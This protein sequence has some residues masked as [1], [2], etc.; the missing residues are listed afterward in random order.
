M[1]REAAE[2]SVSDGSNTKRTAGTPTSRP[3]GESGGGTTPPVLEAVEVTKIYRMGP[4]EIRALDSL[5]LSIY[6]GEL[7]TVM[8]PSG[9]GKTTLLNVLGCLD[10]PDSGKVLLDGEDVTRLPEKART[11]IRLRKIGFIFQQF[12][13]IPTLTA[14]ENVMLPMLEAGLSRKRAAERGR[15]LLEEVGM[16][17]RADHRPSQMS[18]GEQQRTAIAR[19]L[20]N[21]PEIILADEPTGELDTTNAGMVIDLLRRLTAEEGI[22]VVVVTHDPRVAEKGTR[23]INMVDGRVV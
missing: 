6:K 20:A 1:T 23:T 7:L 11:R 2:K 22:T 3:G 14:L 13:L 5:S 21:N 9:S 17:D 4:T 19:A 18:G 10:V 8:G 16:G 15:S 12:Y